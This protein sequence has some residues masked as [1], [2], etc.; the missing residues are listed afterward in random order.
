MKPTL[1]LCAGMLSLIGTIPAAATP[2]LD[3]AAVLAQTVVQPSSEMAVFVDATWMGQVVQPLQEAIK[4]A[5]DAPENAR[6]KPGRTTFANIVLERG[7][8]EAADANASRDASGRRVIDCEGFA[9]M[10]AKTLSQ[11]SGEMSHYAA[12]GWELS[13]KRAASKLAAL[14]KSP[15]FEGSHN[16]V[17]AILDGLIEEMGLERY[18][19]ADAA[20]EA[21][22]EAR[23]EWIKT[24]Y[25]S[26]G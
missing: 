26:A 17:I 24:S 2:V 25:W 19:G 15:T 1:L 14:A 3:A 16:A 13:E 23:K 5:S 22:T 18:E 10:L 12:I 7:I 21:E 20:V 6:K 11:N 4:I 9:K 8:S